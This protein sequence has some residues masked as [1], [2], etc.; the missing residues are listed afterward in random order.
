MPRLKF[1]K[2]RRFREPM[3]KKVLNRHDVK[4]D[5]KTLHEKFVLVPTD[6]AQNNIAFV[7]KKFYIDVLLKEVSPDTKDAKASTY[8]SVNKEL[9][10]ILSDHGKQTK[11]FQVSISEKQMALP[12]LFWIPKMHKRPSKQ[13]F[14]AA[15][16]CCTTKN[17]SA[18][19]TQA[20]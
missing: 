14:I 5:L 15:S 17:V 4:Q 8:V 20:P 13:R 19:L 10:E 16:Y 12:F 3:P 2:F 1:K 6:K 9:K 11:K 7:C 18:I